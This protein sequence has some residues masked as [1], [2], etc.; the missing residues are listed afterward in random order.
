MGPKILKLEREREREGAGRN[1]GQPE[2]L[3]QKFWQKNNAENNLC[4]GQP[5]FLK[6]WWAA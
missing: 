3:G 1:Q 5:N 4:K 6:N 2:F